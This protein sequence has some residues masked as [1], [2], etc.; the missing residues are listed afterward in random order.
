MNFDRACII[1]LALA[2]LANSIGDIFLGQH[3]ATLT[4]PDILD[5]IEKEE[6]PGLDEEPTAE[7][8]TPTVPL[9]IKRR[10]RT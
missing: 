8:P 5:C 4:G 6:C 1:A 10:I 9:L 7:L 2:L 3:V